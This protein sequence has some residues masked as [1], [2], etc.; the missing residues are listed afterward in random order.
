MLPAVAVIAE[1]ESEMALLTAPPPPPP[2]TYF[3]GRGYLWEFLRAGDRVRRRLDA[4]R[5]V[6]NEGKAGQL[7]QEVEVLEWKRRK[8]LK[9]DREVP[10]EIL[11]RFDQY[12]DHPPLPAQARRWV[13]YDLEVLA[14]RGGGV[15]KSGRVGKHLRY[16]GA[17]LD[18]DMAR[19]R[20]LD[21]LHAARCGLEGLG[22]VRTAP[23]PAAQ[24]RELEREAEVLSSK[25]RKARDPRHEVPAAILE[26]FDQ[27]PDHPPLPT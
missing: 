23:A 8:G 26:R 21:R 16:E 14:W 25:W 22:G 19:L 10:A 11:E 2:P 24:V 5:A 18:L 1:R 3:I 13:L 27:Y 15:T 9:P 12:P 17:V 7:E 6:G 4:A 20:L